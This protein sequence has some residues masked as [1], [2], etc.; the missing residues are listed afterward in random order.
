MIK[1]ILCG[2]LAALFVFAAHAQS[3]EAE[4]K[5]S[6]ESALGKIFVGKRIKVDA[7]REASLPGLYEASIGGDVLYTDKKVTYILIGEA[8][9]TKSGVN[10]TE[11]RRKKFTQAQFSTLP[12]DLAVKQVRGN[13]KRV[14]V[15]FEDPNCGYCKKLAREL[16]GFSDITVYT[17]LLPI[18]SADSVEKSKGIWCAR[19]RA[20][21]WN[22]WMIDGI[23][24]PAGKCDMPLDKFRELG[25]K[26]RI[27][28]T[29]ALYFPDGTLIPGYIRAAEIEQALGKAAN[30]R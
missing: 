22:D 14:L 23:E 12:F 17:F 25:A 21:A 2:G 3:M 10:L 20:K 28:G 5:K 19:D 15:T 4:V 6:V 9:D 26:F 18:L 11:E 27:N 24:P 1:R 29:P 8:Y 13:G 7:V 30:S 16:L